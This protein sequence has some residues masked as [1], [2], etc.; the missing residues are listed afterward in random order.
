MEKFTVEEKAL[1]SASL[2][3]SISNVSNSISQVKEEE[4]KVQLRN[5]VKDLLALSEKIGKIK[6]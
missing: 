5:V 3:L 1:L 6:V 2:D 4:Q